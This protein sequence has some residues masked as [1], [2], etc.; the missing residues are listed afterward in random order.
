MATSLVGDGEDKPALW[1]SRVRS[2]LQTAARTVENSE[3]SGVMA[4][5]Y[6]ACK[7]KNASSFRREPPGRPKSATRNAHSCSQRGA[8]GADC[9]TQ[10]H[11][12]RANAMLPKPHRR[13]RIPPPSRSPRSPAPTSTRVEGHKRPKTAAIHHL[14]PPTSVRTPG[15]RRRRAAPSRT[16]PSSAGAPAAAAAASFDR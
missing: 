5:P 12:R 10:R 14:C 2:S 1:P 11:K 13:R 8:T 4:T 16:S 6:S 7:A 9:K 15:A 3:R